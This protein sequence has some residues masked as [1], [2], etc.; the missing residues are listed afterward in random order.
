MKAALNGVSGG[1]SSVFNILSLILIFLLVLVLA[2][3]ASKLAAKYQ[4]NVLNNKSNIRIIESFRLGGNK[5][6]AIAK[7]GES[8]YA[9]GLGKDEITFID[10][11]NPDE[12]KSFGSAG[13][14]DKKL[15]FKEILSQVKNKNS[16]DNNDKSR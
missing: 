10:K 15:N 6:I 13:E 7:I 5:F 16:K 12:L 2:Y 4:S 9:I 3:A 11:I 8:Y 14:A 1:A